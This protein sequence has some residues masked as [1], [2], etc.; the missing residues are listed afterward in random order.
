MGAPIKGGVAIQAPEGSASEGGCNQQAPRCAL[1]P[2]SM[3]VEFGDVFLCLYTTTRATKYTFHHLSMDSMQ[4]VIRFY[5]GYN[6]NNKRNFT[7][8]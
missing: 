2:T 1:L 7:L 3:Q 4:R 5:K 6:S 8:N